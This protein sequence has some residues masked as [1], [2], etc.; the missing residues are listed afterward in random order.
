MRK[1]NSEFLTAFTSEASNDIK[2]TDYFGYVELDD[3]ACY[4][5]ADGIDDQLEAVS[6][7][8]A[9]AA[10]VAAFSEKPSIN[11]R[12]L[13][14]CI[15]AANKALITAKSKTKLKASIVIVITNYVS[16]RY[17]Q[18]GNI[19]LRLYR[20][21]FA[22]EQS[23]DQ[24]LT[25]DL[26]KEDKISQDKV[27]E[28]EERNNLYTYLGQERDFHP[29]ISKKIKLTNSD[30]IALYTRGVW[31]HI[32]EGELKDAFADASDKPEE[33][34]AN[35]EDLLLSRQPE[36]LRK[37]TLTV[38]FANKIFNDPNK[39]R[40]IK[41]IIIIVL[42]IVVVIALIIALA[43][44]FHKKRQNKIEAMQMKYSDTIEYI[45]MNN[46][47]RA[48]ECCN[49]TTELAED[50]RDKKMQTQMG[51]YLKLIEAVI[52]A[53]ELLE[54][55][56]YTQAQAGYRE[57]AIRSKYADNLG[58]D[59]ISDKLAL[60]SG[61]IGVYDYIYLGDSLVTQLM[62]DKA[63]EKY[64]EARALATQIYF[65]KGREEAIAAL[66]KLYEEQK[67]LNDAKDEERQQQLTKEDSAANYVSQ[68]DVAFAAGDYDSAKVYYSGALQRYEELEDDTQ[69]AV[70]ADKLAVTEEKCALKEELAAEAQDY[71]AQAAEAMADGDYYSAKKYYLLA[72][73]VYAG[74][75]DDDKVKEIERKME[76]LEMEEAENKAAEIEDNSSE[77]KETEPI[78]NMEEA[79]PQMPAETEETLPNEN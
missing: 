62:Y 3:Y 5:I 74:L 29:Y 23:Q 17:G 20:D 40:R 66:D 56:E 14:R 11:K 51:N 9:V 79:L 43:L 48:Q 8:L 54:S 65:D 70:I 63:E 71:T 34:V 30:I 28:H 77:N 57:A 42:V 15:K 64:L 38:V 60:T 73:D 7:K 32:D 19:R 75:K 33:T 53:D 25:N 26:L 18:A 59:Y 50:L 1:Q 13:K 55:G 78:V 36:D 27:A 35:I 24:S 22:K 31:E 72:R 46:Y 52:A 69:K 39:K 67:E 21:G 6:A 49:K 61:Y 16:M 10:A 76:L 12:T 47:I 45:Q 2:N 41:K 44:I 58:A 37:Y 4:V 68:G